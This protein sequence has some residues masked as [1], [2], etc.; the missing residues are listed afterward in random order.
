[1]N[2]VTAIIKRK[3]AIF[4]VVAVVYAILTFLIRWGMGFSWNIPIYFLGIFL[5]IFSLD[6]AEE[7]FQLKPSPFRN[8]AF[9]AGFVMVSLFIITSSGS[10]L[11][12]G[13]VLSLHLTLLL[14]QIGEWEIRKNL[15]SWYG[16][17]EK[18][19]SPTY[20]EWGMILF[21]FL[22][23]VETLLFIRS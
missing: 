13:L 21:A 6:A 7:F 4:V 3:P 2:Q 20:Q 8:I 17:M 22:F 9:C 11:A 16:I 1:M 19:V 23:L 18:S 10:A 14:S 12:S 15:D 5:G